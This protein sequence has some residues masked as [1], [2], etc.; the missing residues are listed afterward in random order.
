MLEAHLHSPVT[1]RRLREGLAADHIDGF[2]NWLNLSGYRPISVEGLLRSLAGW[3]DWMLANGFGARDFLRGLEAC[4]LA[5][6]KAPRVRYDRVPKRHSITPAALFIRFLQQ[7]GELPLPPAPP[8]A[9]S[10]RVRLWPGSVLFCGID[11][12]S[13]RLSTPRW[14]LAFY[15]RSRNLGRRCPRAD[16]R[17]RTLPVASPYAGF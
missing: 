4:K 13:R 16:C 1:R 7:Q 3:T 8:R 17:C 12:L 6:H 9:C 5:V 10:A 2:A 14:I 11:L 15:Q